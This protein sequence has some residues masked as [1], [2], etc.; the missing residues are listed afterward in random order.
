VPFEVCEG[1]GL[2]GKDVE[3]LETLGHTAV[4]TGAVGKPVDEV[5]ERW[6]PGDGI[7]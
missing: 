1:G 7:V 4:A 2:E 3:V 5:G 6:G